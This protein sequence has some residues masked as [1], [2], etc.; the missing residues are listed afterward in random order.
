MSK[1]S[2]DDRLRAL[3]VKLAFI[4]YDAH[5]YIEKSPGDAYPVYEIAFEDAFEE[6]LHEEFDND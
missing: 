4:V 1:I 3:A 2:K 6:A 5:F